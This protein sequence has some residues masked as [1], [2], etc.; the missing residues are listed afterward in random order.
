[1]VDSDSPDPLESATVVAVVTACPLADQ[2]QALDE[3]AQSRPRPIM[4]ND[5]DQDQ[6]QDQDHHRTQTRLPEAPS[7]LRVNLSMR[8]TVRTRSTETCHKNKSPDSCNVN[9]N[10]SPDHHSCISYPLSML[11]TGDSKRENRSGER[12]NIG[13]CSESWFRLT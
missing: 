2:D 13:T 11:S 3:A 6:Y 5:Q 4:D 12:T 7:N 1:M 8:C 10:T 9:P